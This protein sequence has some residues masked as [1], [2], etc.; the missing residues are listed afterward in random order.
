LVHPR[1]CPALWADR[2]EDHLRWLAR[3]PD[4][5]VIHIVRR[6]GL[7]WL[8]SKFV[9]QATK[10]YWGKSYPEVR[11]QI[12]PGEAI[13]RLRAKDWVDG[14]LA[15]LANSNP[16]LRLDYE[17]LLADQEAVVA[18]ALR[19][20][21]CDPS[22]APV[23]ERRLRRQSTGTAANYVTNLDDLVVALERHG[24]LVAQFDQR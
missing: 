17:D 3:R 18:R 1:Y 4:I 23:R 15:A 24:L 11:V 12:P 13:A 21:Q 16:Y 22:L 7:E 20:Q 6:D 10:A 5:H 14:R 2:L 9:S 19:F 8:K